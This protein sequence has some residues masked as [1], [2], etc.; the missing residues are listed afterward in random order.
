MSEDYFVYAREW[1][2][3]TADH[4][5]RVVATFSNR[6]AQWHV[7]RSAHDDQRPLWLIPEEQTSP[8]ENWVDVTSECQVKCGRL[9][10]QIIWDL[11]EVHG[12]TS[13]RLRKVENH[14]LVERN[15][16]AR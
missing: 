3:P 10:H 5:L 7:V 15:L 4:K 11:V 9:L 13:Y 6:G 16:S 8:W 2:T 14:L 1:K 12:N